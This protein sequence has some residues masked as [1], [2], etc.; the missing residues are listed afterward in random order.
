MSKISQKV[1]DGE[2]TKQS[3][4]DKYFKIYQIY[5]KSLTNTPTPEIDIKNVQ[6]KS[7][8]LL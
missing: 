3:L 1:S 6:L 2:I 4:K 7:L 8:C 5:L